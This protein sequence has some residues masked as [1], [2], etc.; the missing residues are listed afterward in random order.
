MFETY[1][2]L[3]QAPGLP[4][5]EKMAFLLDDDGSFFTLFKVNDA[6]YPKIFHVGFMQSDTEKVKEI[7]GKLQAGGLEP[8]H[9]REEHGRLTFYVMAPGNFLVEVSSLLV[10]KRADLKSVTSAN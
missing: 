3:V 7:H 1:F 4:C 10:E 5:T 6:V 9:M 8:E 2:G